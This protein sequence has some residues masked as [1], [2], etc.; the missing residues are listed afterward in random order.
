MA[1]DSGPL[2]TLFTVVL[3]REGYR[4]LEARDGVRAVR[5]LAE[6]DVDALF[7]DVRFGLDDGIALAQELRLDWPDLPIAFITGD[8]STA[9]AVNRGAGLA[10]LILTKPFTLPE[11]VAATERLLGSR[12]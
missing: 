5:T 12:E 4:V 8:T 1:D 6:E 2:R 7:L 10:E 3:Q 11:I 9:E